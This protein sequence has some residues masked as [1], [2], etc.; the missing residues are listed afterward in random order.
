MSASKAKPKSK[1]AASRAGR[2]AADTIDNVRA[3]LNGQPDDVAG[4]AQTGFEDAIEMGEAMVAQVC[5][6]VEKEPWKAVAIAG[7]VG[8]L[9]GLAVRR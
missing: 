8:L 6:F 1:R 5:D 2:A 7:A 9:I 3:E 4:M